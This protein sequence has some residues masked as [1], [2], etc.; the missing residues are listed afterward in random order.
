MGKMLPIASCRA[1]ILASSSSSLTDPIL[2]KIC[3]G[4]DAV[5]VM[6]EDQ[7]EQRRDLSF[8]SITRETLREY[9]HRTL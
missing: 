3:R 5:V 2:A 1:Y 7:E 6:L 9:V 8:W 4:N